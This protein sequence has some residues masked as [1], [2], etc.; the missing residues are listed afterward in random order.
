MFKLQ[1][2]IRTGLLL[3]ALCFLPAIAQ[4]AP[5]QEVTAASV[6]ERFHQALGGKEK[7]AEVKTMVT[8]GK[9]SIPEAGAEGTFTSTQKAPNSSLTEIEVPGAGEFK[10]V[11][12]GETAWETGT[13]GDRIKTDREFEESKLQSAMFPF[14][15][16]PAGYESVEVTGKSEFAGAACHEL[17][18]RLKT[19][20]PPITCYFSEESG[21]LVGMKGEFESQM[22]FINAV[23]TI[24]DYRDVDGIK[25]AFKGTTRINE[26]FSQVLESES[27]VIN[28]EL[29]D[30]TFAMPESIAKLKKEEA[31]KDGGA[32]PAGDG[33]KASGDGG[34]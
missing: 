9:F 29:A 4:A 27:V 14:W 19:D 21:L 11:F 34:N 33:D 26:Q 6:I 15:D 3:A 17:T 2:I 22:G 31:D 7:L 16:F 32:A 13:N 30:D 23:T 18:V 8:K 24:E 1:M 12:D 5:V 10:S 28:P 25:V 20:V